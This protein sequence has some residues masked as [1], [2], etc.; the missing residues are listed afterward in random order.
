MFDSFLQIWAVTTFNPLSQWRCAG[1]CCE[2]HAER[3]EEA[4]GLHL[5]S[6]ALAGAGQSEIIS[7]LAR[8]DVN[9][10][11]A[12]T[13]YLWSRVSDELA[14]T[15]AVWVLDAKY[16]SSKCIQL[17]TKIMF[18][19]R[20]KRGKKHFDPCFILTCFLWGQ[21][22]WNENVWGTFETATETEHKMFVVGCGCRLRWT[23]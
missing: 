11:S 3:S 14:W 4:G 13:A 21:T 8:P 20:K 6:L 12:V 1:L 16:P 17:S 22:G 23:D 9:R 19:L 2:D 15:T 7:V 18:V 10:C 5:C